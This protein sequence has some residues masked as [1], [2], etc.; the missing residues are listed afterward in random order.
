MGLYPPAD[1]TKALGGVEKGDA[2][3]ML[4]ATVTA[5][6]IGTALMPCACAACKAIGA[7]NMAVTVFDIKKVSNEVAT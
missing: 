1:I 4:A 7:I 5:I 6:N 3:H 2:K